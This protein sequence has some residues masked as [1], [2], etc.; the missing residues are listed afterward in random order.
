VTSESIGLPSTPAAHRFVIQ[1]WPR[2]QI[3]QAWRCNSPRA[4]N[5]AYTYG[6]AG[7]QAKAERELEKL[8]ALN[9]RTPVDPIV[10]AQA[11]V[12]MGKHDQAIFW[13]E[14]AYAQRSNGLTALSVD[15]V[16]DPLRGE[17]GF[18]IFLRR[19]GLTQ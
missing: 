16:Y 11:Y 5:L 1:S 17:P 14:K 15:P 3:Q 12:G 2:R 9:R 18:Q 7:E 4:S 6:R 13:L 8:L 10:I 19:V